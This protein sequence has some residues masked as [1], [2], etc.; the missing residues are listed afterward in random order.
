VLVEFGVEAAAVALPAH[1][2]PHLVAKLNHLHVYRIAAHHI[3][4][5][6]FFFLNTGLERFQG[7]LEIGLLPEVLL[8][9]FDHRLDLFVE[10]L[11]F[12]QRHFLGAVPAH[13]LLE[14]RHQFLHFH[15][16]K[17][18]LR[19][20]QLI[21]SRWLSCE[22]GHAHLLIGVFLP[23]AIFIF[24]T[25]GRHLNRDK[26]FLDLRLSLR[27]AKRLVRAHIPRAERL[28]LHLPVSSQF[29]MLNLS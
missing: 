21:F 7:E 26:T 10:L 12:D 14:S 2:V 27:P 19:K 18:R 6:H 28:M 4:L 22:R 9:V 17:S 20:F 1:H 8:H 13:S 5:R 3:Y 23:P 11:L 15:F 25:I 24:H 29:L 16:A